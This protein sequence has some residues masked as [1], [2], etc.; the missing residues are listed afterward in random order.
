MTKVVS[1]MDIVRTGFQ[2]QQTATKTHF[3]FDMRSPVAYNFDV[4]AILHCILS[5]S[6]IGIHREMKV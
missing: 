4:L 5:N 6:G 2:R 3:F 1:V